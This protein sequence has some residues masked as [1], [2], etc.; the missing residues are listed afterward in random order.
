VYKVFNNKNCI[1]AFRQLI[2]IVLVTACFVAIGYSDVKLG[3]KT[4]LEG[5]M[6]TK[7]TVN[8]LSLEFSVIT[9]KIKYADELEVRAFFTNESKATMRVKTLFLDLPIILLKIRNDKGAPV[10]LGPPPLPPV[11]DGVIGRVDLTPG[12]S[13]RYLYYGINIFSGKMLQPGVYEI[14]FKY[15]NEYVQGEEWRGVIETDWIEFRIEK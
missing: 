13:L 15:D 14:R 3:S 5:K 12:Q 7:I 1:S 10:L 2:T 11:D 8:Q 9:P 6:E 4:N